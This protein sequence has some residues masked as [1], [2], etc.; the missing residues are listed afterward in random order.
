[1][2]KVPKKA[3]WSLWTPGLAL[4]RLIHTDTH[5]LQN[6]QTFFSARKHQIHWM[7]VA[8]D[9]TK[10]AKCLWF[11]TNWTMFDYDHLHS[12][13]QKSN[14][15][16]I[17]MTPGAWSSTQ[18]Q[19][20][21]KHLSFWRLSR[22][23]SQSVRLAVAMTTQVMIGDA[24]F[25]VCVCRTTRTTLLRCVC[26]CMWGPLS[27]SNLRP[28]NSAHAVLC[29]PGS[30]FHR[31]DTFNLFTELV[32]NAHEPG[33]WFL[34][35]PVGM[36]AELWVKPECVLIQCDP[37]PTRTLRVKE[38]LVMSGWGVTAAL[39]EGKYFWSPDGGAGAERQA[40]MS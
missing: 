12:L 10:C 37:Q 24:R 32:H 35:R 25:C 26:L 39:G 22:C 28:P 40:E 1:M 38:R 27:A 17:S 30:V 2:A 16:S 11:S 33:S 31:L 7:L 4:L 14:N 34:K 36:R 3:R 9:M 29:S 13:I 8:K 5:K 19:K 21:K 20:Q 15:Y 6:I 18:E 23:L